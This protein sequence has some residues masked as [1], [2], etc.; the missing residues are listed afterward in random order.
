MNIAFITDT[1]VPEVNGVAR[2]LEQFVLVLAN[3]G[4]KITVVR[5]RRKGESSEKTKTHD[6]FREI[7]LPSFPLPTYTEVRFGIPIKEYL[8]KVFEEGHLDVIYVATETILGIFAMESARKKGIK[9]ISAYHTNFSQYKYGYMDIL[10]D[11]TNGYLRWFHSRA[12]LTIVQSDGVKDQLTK[13]GFKNLRKIS[14][15]VDSEL[16][17]PSKRSEKLRKS[18]GADENTIVAIYVGRLAEE[19]NVATSLNIIREAR[20][21]HANMTGVVVGNGPIKNEL[22]EKYQDFIF[23]G[24]QSGEELAKH[25]ASADL[26][27]FASITET[28]GHVVSEAM[29]SGIVYI[30]YNYAGPKE[31]IISGENGF[32]VDFNNEDLLRKKVIEVVTSWPHYDVRIEA[33]ETAGFYSWNKVVDDLEKVFEEVCK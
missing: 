30:G 33:R 18:W 28:F 11:A 31:R 25:Y 20:K 5:P 15:G 1:F 8:D 27:V 26:F 23:V 12:D 17:N 13:Q 4:H 9:I 10:E 29:A 7:I 24:V 21:K 2:T 19:K 3:K 6:S 16:F 32:L 22:E 14:R